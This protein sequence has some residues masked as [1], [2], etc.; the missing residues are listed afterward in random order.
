MLAVSH[1]IDSTSGRH[2]VAGDTSWGRI[3]A[4]TGWRDSPLCPYSERVLQCDVADMVPFRRRGFNGHEARQFLRNG[5]LEE[6]SL[7]PR[8]RSRLSCRDEVV[9]SG[10]ES[11][12]NAVGPCIGHSLP[13]SIYADKHAEAVT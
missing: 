2:R 8:S 13:I 3:C 7:L 1:A 4:R 12:L 6:A 11:S 10:G 9:H 5:A